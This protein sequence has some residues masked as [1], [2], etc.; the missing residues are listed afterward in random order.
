MEEFRQQI[1]DRFVLKL[2]N[3]G[4]V[5]KDDFNIKDGFVFINEDC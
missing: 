5:S 2:I 4:Q 3:L 1:V